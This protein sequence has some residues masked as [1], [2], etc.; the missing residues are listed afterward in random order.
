L[1]H[2]G[3]GPHT[4]PATETINNNAAYPRVQSTL[5]GANPFGVY[6]LIP[7]AVTIVT[8]TTRLKRRPWQWLAWLA[9]LVLA[10]AFSFSRSAWIGSFL[11][12]LTIL[13]VR[14]SKKAQLR[15]WLLPAAI[16]LIVAG[17]A[18]GLLVHHNRGV[19]NAIL[20]TDNKSTSLHSSNE[21]HAS[22]LKAG[23]SQVLH[24]PLGRGVGT[25]G[26]ASVY[27]G[28][29]V[30]IAENYYVQIGQEMGWMGL[31]AYAVLTILLGLSLWRRR[32][33]PLA[34]ALFA[35]LVG[36]SF[37]NLLSH[38]WADDTLSYLWWGLAGLALAL[39][40]SKQLKSV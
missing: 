1:R 7:L 2:F 25:A 33:E 38:A 15:R 11:V 34:L 21:N 16:V 20:H 13:A 28:R 5:R 27:N 12:I 9:L 40:P 23:I 8:M 3:Y 35:S 6:L 31:L 30:R 24:Q 37:V 32:R 39:P 22:A 29:K 26:P 14:F 36:I 10:L 19:Q 4:I 17:V 18:I